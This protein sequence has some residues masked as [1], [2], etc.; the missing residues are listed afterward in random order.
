M[1]IFHPDCTRLA[2]SGV[3]WYHE[4]PEYQ[5]LTIQA[6]LFFNACLY[7]D[8]PLIAVENPIQHRYARQYIRKYDQIIQP[9]QFGDLE[10]KATCLWLKGIA[11]LNPLITVKPDNVKQSVWR[12]P[13]GTNRKVNR[14]R[15]FPGIAKAMADQWGELLLNQKGEEQC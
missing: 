8:I 9:W 13:P 15:T 3:R 7:A 6:A 14:S 5:E 4:R 11:R 10:S 2:N 12:E 1:A